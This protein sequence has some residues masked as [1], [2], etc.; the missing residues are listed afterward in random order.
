MIASSSL[1][2]FALLKIAQYDKTTVVFSDYRLD[3]ELEGFERPKNSRFVVVS[4]HAVVKVTI[5]LVEEIGN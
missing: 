3:L 4:Y 1:P 5:P 2:F